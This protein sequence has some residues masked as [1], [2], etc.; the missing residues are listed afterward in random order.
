M[1]LKGGRNDNPTMVQATYAIRHSGWTTSGPAADGLSLPK[2]PK[3]APTKPCP[4][5]MAFYCTKVGGNFGRIGE[6][7]AVGHTYNYVTVE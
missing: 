2:K 3:S 1:R 7:C 6:I 4:G 5:T